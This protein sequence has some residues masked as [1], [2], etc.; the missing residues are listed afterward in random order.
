MR[1]R[2]AR[3]QSVWGAVVVY[4]ALGVP[5]TRVCHEATASHR[6][7][8]EHHAMEEARDAAADARSRTPGAPSKREHQHETCPFT[9]LAGQPTLSPELAVS[10]GTAPSLAGLLQFAALPP[11]VRPAG[12]LSVAPKT[13]PPV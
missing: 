11:S 1:R 4:M 9:P 10:T 5:I 3:L 13:S 12:V 7:C 6:Y 2:S 8:A